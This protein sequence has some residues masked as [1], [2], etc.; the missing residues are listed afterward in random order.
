MDIYEI[1]KNTGLSQRAFAEKY[2]IPVRTIENWESG[3]R[4]P[5]QYVID[6]LQTIVE[7][8]L[9]ARWYVVENQHIGGTEFLETVIFSGSQ[10]SCT[11]YENELRKTYPEDRGRI[12]CWTVNAADYQKTQMRATGLR[13]YMDSLPEKEKKAVVEIGGRRYLKAVLDFNSMLG[14]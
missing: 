2:R 6:M 4:K 10:E 12:D 7:Q 5:P 8:D 9:Q 11:E 3:E 1:R 13:E 14:L